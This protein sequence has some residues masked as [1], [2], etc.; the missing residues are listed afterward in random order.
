MV[1]RVLTELPCD[2]AFVDGQMPDFAGGGGAWRAS[3]VVMPC[4]INCQREPLHDRAFI[5]LTPT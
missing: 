5:S 1:P 2:T 3:G 4:K